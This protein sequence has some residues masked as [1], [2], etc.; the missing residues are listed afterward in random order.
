MKRR[1]KYTDEPIDFEV[2][3]DFLPPPEKLALKQESVK[4][5]ISLNKATVDFFKE[6]AKKLRTP[7]Q[8]MIRRVLDLYVSHYR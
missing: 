7:Y 8:K 2:I 3:D 6:Y 4:V 1:I 5:T